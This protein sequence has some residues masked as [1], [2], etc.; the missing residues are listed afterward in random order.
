MREHI[1]GCDS[2]WYKLKNNYTVDVFKETLCLKTNCKIQ[3][4][5]Q[6]YNDGE[7]IVCD[8]GLRINHN[9][10]LK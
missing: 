6:E 10:C 5:K 8:T 9:R 3:L 4:L 7:T 2:Q 1:S